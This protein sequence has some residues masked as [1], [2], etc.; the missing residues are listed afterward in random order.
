MILVMKFKGYLYIML[1]FNLKWDDKGIEY[2][3]LIY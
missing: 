2:L 1:R 3:L